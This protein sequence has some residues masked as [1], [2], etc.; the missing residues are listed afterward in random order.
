MRLNKP[1]ARAQ[2]KTNIGALSLAACADAYNKETVMAVIGGFKE[3]AEFFAVRAA[4]ARDPETKQRHAENAE[5]YT[6]LA[7]IAPTCPK[8]YIIPSALNGNRWR[9]RAELC[10]T[11]AESFRDPTCR[12][13]LFALAQTYDGLAQQYPY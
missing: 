1:R 13:Q 8:G 9:N 10:R 3:S 12:H 2:P 6:K 4:K 5:F 11:M 7:A